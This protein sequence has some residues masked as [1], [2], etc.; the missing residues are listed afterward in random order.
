MRR[1]L[2]AVDWPGVVAVT[3]VAL[4]AAGAV[5]VTV[6]THRV[7]PVLGTNV[8]ASKSPEPSPTPTPS[9]PAQTAS[10]VRLSA[11]TANVLWALVDYEALFVSTDAG[12]HWAKRSLPDNAGVRPS[13]TFIDASEGWLLA[14]GG[15][16]TECDVQLADL[17][18]TTDGARSWQ[19]LGARIDKSQCKNGI[20]FFDSTH[21]LVTAWSQNGRPTVY[22]TSDAGDHWASSAVPD[23]PIFVTRPGGFTLHVNW[24]KPFGTT[25]YMQASGSQD[26]PSWHDR[27]FMYTSRD[28]G[29]TWTWKQKLGSPFTFLVSEQRW[30]QLG[31]DVMESVNGGQQFHPFTT[32]L[33]AVPPL[34]ATFPDAV[35]GYVAAGGAILRTVDGGAHWA[36]LQTPWSASETPSPAP[37]PSP[38]IAPVAVQLSAPSADVVWALVNDGD[39]FRSIDGG[40]SW[41]QRPW[42]PYRGGGGNPVIS[43]VD[44]M[45]GWALFPGVPSTQCQ[46]AGAQI[47]HTTDA[48]ATWSLISEVT[49]QK[50]SSTGLPFV[51]CKEYTFF[52]NPKV[53]FVAGHDTQFQPVISRTVDGGR[54]WTRARL[55]DPPGFKTGGDVTLPVVDIKPFGS[56]VLAVAVYRASAYVF[57]SIDLGATWTYLPTAKE[58]AYG[59]VT[60]VTATHWLNV[61]SRIQTSDAG[62]TTQ[63]FSTDYGATLVGSRFTFA[64]VFVGYAVVDG[65]L[66]RTAD[67]GVHWELVKTSWP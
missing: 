52:A 20:W 10:E 28:G 1:T 35:A 47:W 50:Q 54:T 51:Q 15:S 2:S 13:I 67:G 21:G 62:R 37:T 56:V 24:I 59:L 61:Q 57:K 32:D 65:R 42:A 22:R 18:H 11:P 7:G 40:A 48:G 5:G 8:P 31:S 16:A 38:V 53:G 3:L 9:P 41:Q 26:D 58:W 34:Q 39:L 46:Q 30:L 66:Y 60:I 49:Y 17:W 29:A 27:D 19:D 45:Q 36:Q 33:R 4:L 12:G 63:P 43:F 44:D 6:A 14:P 23:N 64:T 25:I 55:P